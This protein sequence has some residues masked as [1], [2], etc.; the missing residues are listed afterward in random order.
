MFQYILW[1]DFCRFMVG[2]CRDNDRRAAAAEKLKFSLFQAISKLAASYLS[3]AS[4]LLSKAKFSSLGVTAHIVLIFSVLSSLYRRPE[5]LSPSAGQ[6]KRSPAG[7]RLLSH[8]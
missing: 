8:T 4:P 6:S 1:V 2:F 5:V 3:S 7:A